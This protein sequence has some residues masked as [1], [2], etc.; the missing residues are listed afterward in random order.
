[1]LPLLIASLLLAEPPA[2]PV[3]VE[4]TKPRPDLTALFTRT[5]GWTGSDGAYSIPL[6]PKRILWLFGDTWIGRVEDGRRVDS[7]MI[8]NSTAWMDLGGEPAVRF[9]WDDSAKDPAALLRP[10]A[11]GEWYWPGDGAVVDG[12]LYLFAHVIRHKEKGAPGF[13]FDWF[14][15]ELLRIDNPADEPAKWKI[16]R[17]RLGK[18]LKLGVACCFDGDYLYAFANVP[19]PHRPL[20]SP[21]AVTRIA[22]SKLA[23]LD[24]GGFEC[25]AK[26][27]WT[28]DLKSAEPIFRD[29]ATEMSVQRLRGIDGW[30]AVYM[31][32][33]ISGD[34]AVRHAERPEGPWSAPLKVY[35]C[36]KEAK[37]VFLYAAK[38]HAELAQRD[39]QLIV[40]YCRNIGALGEHVKRPDIYAPQFVEI[41]LRKNK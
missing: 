5:S 14:A 18:E 16:E 3:I 12:K 6:S 15:D 33:G 19:G 10:A 36:P 17:R 28:S 1:M 37:D 20:D 29:G 22:K 38:G 11:A 13:Q 26:D 35:R 24:V 9:F 25:R 27:G 7:R 34:I 23:K 30:I 39:G 8:N 2:S 31:P 40:T 32:L 4:S 41:Q 21:L